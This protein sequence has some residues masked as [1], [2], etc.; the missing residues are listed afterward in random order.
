MEA[1]IVKFNYAVNEV[2]N[3]VDP[4][5]ERVPELDEYKKVVSFVL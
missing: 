4:F 1:D 5:R 2:A 3:G